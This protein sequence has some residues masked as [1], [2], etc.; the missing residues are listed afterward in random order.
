MGGGSFVALLNNTRSTT[1]STTALFDPVYSPSW[2]FQFT[3]PLA[4]GR[5]IDQ[6]RQQLV[7][8]KLNREMSD[9]QLQSTIIN[10]LSNVR[11]AYWNYVYATQA[12]EVAR[13]S[14]A[15]AE[16]LIRDNQVRVEVGV[17]APIDV[18]TAQSQAAQQRQSL[19]QAESNRRTSELALKRLIVNGT[20]D[21]T[22]NASIEPVDQPDFSP[23]PVDVDAAVRRA[24]TTRSDLNTARKNNDAN[25]ETLKYLRDQTLPQADLVARYGLTGLG[26]TEFIATGSGINRVVT[27]VVPG[28]FG[29]AISTLLGQSYPTWSVSLNV[30]YAIGTNIV[31]AQV[32]RARVQMEQARAQTR[33]IE[34]QVATEVTNAAINVQNAVEA[35]QAAQAAQELAQKTMEAEQGKFDVGISTNYN[36]ILTQRDLNTAKNSYLLAVLN[37]RNALVEL[38]R[39]QQTTLQSVNVT[40]LAPM[41]TSGAV[42][43]PNLFWGNIGSGCT[44]AT[45]VTSPCVP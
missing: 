32:A 12:V 33:Q 22:W 30:S 15:I 13:Q 37:Y 9:L 34:L 40:L 14:V 29:N 2:T 7:V 4:R 6:T 43:S 10:T 20:E 39:L 42:G 31:A 8:S 11:E 27:G 1:T 41:G 25:A 17:L 28:G 36:V 45:V 21:P 3:Q 16:Q 18:V 44:A 23:Q 26:G 24:L 5:A 19:V 38:D 35:V